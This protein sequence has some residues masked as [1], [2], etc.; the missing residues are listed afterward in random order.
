MAD[1]GGVEKKPKEVVDLELIGRKDEQTDGRTVASRDSVRQKIADD[2]EAF[3]SKGGRIDEI[4][5][6][7]TADPPKKP[8]NNYGSRAI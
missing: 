5:P 2:I 7:V 1:T 6:D 4:A 3:L 8:E